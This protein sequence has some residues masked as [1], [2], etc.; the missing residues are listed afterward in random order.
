MNNHDDDNKGS[1]AKHRNPW[2]LILISIG[3]ITLA[4]L[5]LFLPEIK[6]DA[7][8]IGLLVVAILPWIGPLLKSIELPGGIKFELREEI[9]QVESK[10]TSQI[11]EEGKKRHEISERVQQIEHVLFKGVEVKT[12]V[13]KKI[14]YIL[15]QFDTYLKSLGANYGPFP[16]I[17]VKDDLPAGY[18]AHYDANTKELVISKDWLEDHDVIFREYCYHAFHQPLAHNQLGKQISRAVTEGASLDA[19]GI[20]SGFG[21]Y[22]PCSYK[23]SPVFGSLKAPVLDRNGLT[24][25]VT[26]SQEANQQRSAMAIIALGERWAHAFWEIRQYMDAE[27][28]DRYLIEAWKTV[29][30]SINTEHFERSFIDKIAM[31]AGKAKGEDSAVFVRDTF[32]KWKFQG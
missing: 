17:F 27:K 22:F 1:M 8:T 15:E 13:K 5:R 19:G 6:I 20:I 24:Y 12:D 16:T 4:S 21:F 10:L 25:S 29:P 14:N 18:Q 28:F 30:K 11:H 9:R 2:V 7:I 3:A 32:K 31:L 26:S 23:Q